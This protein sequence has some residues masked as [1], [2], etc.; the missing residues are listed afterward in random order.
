MALQDNVETNYDTLTEVL[1]GLKA[2]A[3]DPAITPPMFQDFVFDLE[4][5]DLETFVYKEQLANPGFTVAYAVDEIHRIEATFREYLIRNTSKRTYY[6]SSEGYLDR[7]LAYLTN[8]KI[9]KIKYF[10]G[11]MQVQGNN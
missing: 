9:K 3:A 11:E 7:E 6:S 10:L 2:F 5:A 1:E 4:Y 8:E